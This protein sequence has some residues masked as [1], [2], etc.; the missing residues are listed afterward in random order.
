MIATMLETGVLQ[1]RD[2][3][4]EFRETTAIAALF[5]NHIEVVAV[6]ESPQTVHM[7]N[8]VGRILQ[9]HAS[10]LGKVITAF[11]PDERREHLIR[12]YGVTPLTAKTITD[13][14]I[15]QRELEQV[16]TRGYATDAGETCLEGHCFGA[17]IYGPDGDVV[18][19][20]SMSIPLVRLGGPDQQAKIVER[21]KAT[22]A[23]IS[24]ALQS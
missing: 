1:I 22:A 9:P 13:E 21:V 10:S 23:A 18:A 8:T 24:A 19:A 5:D 15:L 7:G 11:Q 16:R 4:R 20:V 2:L 3:T 17:P 12:S 14:N 6:S